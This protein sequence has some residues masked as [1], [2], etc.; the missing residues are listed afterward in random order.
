[1]ISGM[2]P[3]AKGT[4]GYSRL[5][6]C[7]GLW[8]APLLHVTSF[9]LMREEVEPFHTGFYSLAWW[10]YIGFISALNHRWR[11]NSLLFDRWRE[12]RWLFLV[13]TPVWLF[14]ELCNFRL[15]NWHYIGVPSEWWIRLPGYFIAFGTVLPGI[16]ETQTLL[17]NG[18]LRLGSGKMGAATSSSRGGR[19]ALLGGLMLGAAL[20]WPLLFFPL[21]WVGPVLMLRWLVS[22]W[23]EKGLAPPPARGDYSFTARLLLS[24]LICGVLWEF[25]N[26]WAGAKWV[27]SI[28]YL[29]GFPVFEMPLAG[30]LGFPPFALICYLMYRLSIPLRSWITA[31]R[32]R[33]A[34]VAVLYV[35]GC[36]LVFLGIERLTVLEYKP[37]WPW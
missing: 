14:F 19:L 15:H 9:W 35:F 26:F 13:S 23:G 25:W 34:L 6:A 5:A 11:N 18:G 12:F 10:S 2:G 36:W 16:F 28:P 8:L 32:S 37:F 30:F 21:V 33:L 29:N 31:S 27:Y 22:V 20:V 3:P 7:A 17:Q 1:M 4:K 24:G